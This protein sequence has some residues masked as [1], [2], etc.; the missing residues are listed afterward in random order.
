M[1][2]NIIILI[3]IPF[4]YA[5]VSLLKQK[6]GTVKTVVTVAAPTGLHMNVEY[7]AKNVRRSI[8][9]QGAV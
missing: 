5:C 6:S 9:M 3:M 7:F 8:H 4:F 2:M 1:M